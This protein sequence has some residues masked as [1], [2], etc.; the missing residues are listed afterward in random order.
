M[1]GDLASALRSLRRAP[2]FTGLVVLTLALGI[3]ATTAMFSVVDA[4]VIN[5]LPFPKA[6]R[7]VEVWTNYRQG[8]SRQPGASN[9]VVAA[10]KADTRL[11][12]QVEAYQF[13]SGTLTGAG[14]PE[15]VSLLNWAV[16]SRMKT[17]RLPPLSC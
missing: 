12:E 14:E 17:L 2:A 9:A 6:E 8:A 16:S 7:V 5:P 11:F 15:Q 4:V 13:G 10:L 3:G 1:R